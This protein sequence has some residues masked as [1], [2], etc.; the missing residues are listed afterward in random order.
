MKT[1]KKT[2]MKRGAVCRRRRLGVGGVALGSAV[3]TLELSCIA[4]FLLTRRPEGP[5]SIS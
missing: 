4:G 5:N 1:T 3:G 2:D